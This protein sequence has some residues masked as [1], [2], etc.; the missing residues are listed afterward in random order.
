ME[1]FQWYVDTNLDGNEELEDKEMNINTDDYEWLR[2][3]FIIPNS[4]IELRTRPMTYLRG[5]KSKDGLKGN[6]ALETHLL[7]KKQTIFIDQLIRKKGHTN[8]GITIKKQRATQ[9]FWGW[10]SKN[11]LRF[12]EV[13]SCRY[14][15]DYTYYHDWIYSSV[16]QRQSSLDR[17]SY[18]L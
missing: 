10:F 7:A 14:S 16:F 4:M 6:Q 17:D 3:A 13:S 8:V 12:I 15:Y 5:L 9:F 11:R 1:L 18:G 2:L